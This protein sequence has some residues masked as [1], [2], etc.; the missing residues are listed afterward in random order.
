M[1]TLAG[2]RNF[3]LIWS[4][5]L[6]SSVGS[7]LSSF[8]LGIWVLKTT[9]STSKFALIFVCMAI[10]AV[11]LSPFA[12]ALV[13]RWDRRKTMMLCDLSCSVLM[14]GQAALLAAGALELWHIYL[15]AALA[16]LANAFHA[17]AYLASVPLLASNEQ[18]TRANGLIQTTE[19][20]AMIA[21]PLLAGVLVSMMSVQGVLLIDGLT[22]LAA[23]FALSMA[24]VP[25]PPAAPQPADSL[26]RE[27]AAGFAYVR[28]QRGLL[29]LL[30]VFGVSNFLFA[31][32]SILITPLVL[33]FA[34]EIQLGEQFAIGGAGLFLGGLFMTISGGF[35]QRA[36]AA[37]AFYCI[38]GLALALHGV[39]ANFWLVC[40]MG[41]VFFLTLPIINASFASVWQS[42]IAPHML[43]RCFA[44]QRVLS[45]SAMPV[46][47]VLAG[48]LAE[49]WF[50]PMLQPGGALAASVGAVI[51]VGAGRGVGLIFIVL[52]LAM[53]LTAM[54]ALAQPAIRSVDQL[55]DQ[56]P[57]DDAADSARASP[58]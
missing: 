6:V 26:Y 51:G 52:G 3:L 2:L 23:V 17:P 32:A 9:G 41:F 11:L 24:R 36:R 21:G 57:P 4:G 56:A 25:R 49:N 39:A 46:G 12:G 13:D 28:Q 14:L 30:G 29:G 10:P 22:F 38:A 8:A 34:T 35:K 50:D 18:L 27:A 33:S 48:P 1:N 44:I 58:A 43:G 5:Q 45:E 37:L 40:G 16:A 15:G 19:A 7:R 53:L 47:Y 55:P 54:L 31:I 20:V 42:K